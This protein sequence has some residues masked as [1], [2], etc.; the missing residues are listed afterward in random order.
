M[1]S[2]ANVNLPITNLARKRLAQVAGC[3][4]FHAGTNE[5]SGAL[6]THVHS[7]WFQTFNYPHRAPPAKSLKMVPSQEM[8][9]LQRTPVLQVCICAFY[10]TGLT[11]NYCAAAT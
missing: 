1:Y 11:T 7:S 2:D 3:G 5:V 4:D 10:T 8:I 9:P 6:L